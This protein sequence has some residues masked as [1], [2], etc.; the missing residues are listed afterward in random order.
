MNTAEQLRELAARLLALAMNAK[1]QDL[2]ERLC[3]RAGECLDQ[4]GL[5]EAG[6]AADFEKKIRPLSGNP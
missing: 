4:A 1:D 6:Q 5:L 3:V 2:L